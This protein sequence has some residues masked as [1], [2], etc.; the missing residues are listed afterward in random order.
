MTQVTKAI[1]KSNKDTIYADNSS[2]QISEA[3]HRSTF[4]DVAD[5]FVLNNGTSSTSNMILT[6]SV[7]GSSG[8]DRGFIFQPTVNQSGT[9]GYESFVVN[10]TETAV[11]SGINIL[12]SLKT[13]NTRTFAFHSD[14]VFEVKE[15]TTP[16]TPDASRG[17]F[18]VD[19]SDSLPKFKNDAGTVYDLSATAPVNPIT[20]TG[21]ATDVSI[22]FTES[23][24]AVSFI[25]GIDNSDS[26]RFKIS[27]S[28]ALGTSD[29][30][31]IDSTT[32]TFSSV[33]PVF[34]FAGQGTT[35]EVNSLDIIVD[36][37][38][39]NLV[40][41]IKNS[42]A[43]GV[44]NILRMS[45]NNGASNFIHFDTA[46]NDTA[47]GF[48]D[49]GYFYITNSTN[50]TSNQ[51]L[52]INAGESHSFSIES[53]VG[54]SSSSTSARTIS[55]YNQGTG[56]ALFT[57]RVTAQIWGFGIDNSDADKFKISA[58]G[59]LGTN[60][61]IV[62]DTSNNF[63]LPSLPTSSAGLPSGAVWSNSGVLTIV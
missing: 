24:S 62:L 58:G 49:D 27:R 35:G 5:S 25:M 19:S 60:D 15:T 38:T 21:S 45:L 11:G 36:S 8:I 1:F 14:G 13:A 32:A 54:Y 26:D 34:N 23:D 63:I 10:V 17:F 50:I 51:I 16:S 39:D 42:S 61:V 30:L 31:Y 46:G 59:V 48:A 41:W 3:D 37:G 43:S 2:Q 6:S 55:N 22:T 12:A 33:K 40:T 52:T 20:L 53:G 29:K 57:A 28:S 9:A 18:Y 4:E 44:D 7:T 56:D 47:L